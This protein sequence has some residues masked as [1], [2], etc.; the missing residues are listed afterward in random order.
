MVYLDNAATTFPKPASVAI[1]L[2]DV[3]RQ[4]IG[5][6]G[7]AGHRW[8]RQGEQILADAR[9]LLNQL[10]HGQDYERFILTL[11]GTD[12]LNIAIKG[13]IEPGDHV[14]TGTLEH[15]SVL[16][17]LEGLRQTKQIEIHYL[18]ADDR[19]YYRVE[20]LR[21]AIRPNTKL[22][23]LTHAS[24]VLGTV[25]PIQE[26]GEIC[27]AN[28]VLY[29]VD[30]AQTAGCWP[31]DIEQMKID[32]LAAPG[33]KALFGPTGT[34]FLYVGPR[35]KVRPWREGGTGSHSEERE[36]P[37]EL[38]DRLEA[39]T[40]NVHGIA[41]LVAGLRHIRETTV[42]SIQSHERQWAKELHDQLA[43]VPGLEV[44]SRGQENARVAIATF[45]VEGYTSQEIVSI[46][47]SA[48]DVAVRGG[49][50]CAPLVHRHL[51]TTPEGTVRVSGSALTSSEDIRQ[52]IDA[53]RQ[54]S[55]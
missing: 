9:H 38:P 31:I 27:R 10:F 28:N 35:A 25:Q 47:D 21:R 2:D 11:N 20:D 37:A 3:W 29:L 32:L 26:L 4:G 43:T 8:A 55:G 19:G 13:I 46:L 36:Q 41:G 40:A 44:L 54:I 16:R 22:V 6:P 51:G 17:P 50:H 48:F 52:L 5:N 34:G 30:A 24:N 45:N 53:L 12:A 42:T 14:I 39:G 15:N 18:N 23:A 7:R 1:A 33:H 49:L